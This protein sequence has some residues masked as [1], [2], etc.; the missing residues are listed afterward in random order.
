MLYSTFLYH[1]KS[2]RYTSPHTAVLI[3]LMVICGIKLQICH[4]FLEFMSARKPTMWRGAMQITYYNEKFGKHNQM[5][6]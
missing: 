2:E 5:F 3:L 4:A 1:L 6:W